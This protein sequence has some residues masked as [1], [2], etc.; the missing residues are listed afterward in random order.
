MA[1]IFRM[2]P[3]ESAR[4]FERGLHVSVSSP[5]DIDPRQGISKP[6]DASVS[7]L[8][9]VEVKVTQPAKTAQEDQAG[10]GDPCSAKVESLQV[11]QFGQSRKTGIGNLCTV[12][13][14][15]HQSRQ[16]IQVCQP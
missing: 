8:R 16:P 9:F 10:V 13:I 12:Q 5:K 15:M 2:A 11:S 1:H 3:K 7:R 14:E 4:E 6:G